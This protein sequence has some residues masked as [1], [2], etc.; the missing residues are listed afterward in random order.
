MSEFNQEEQG[1]QFSSSYQ[2]TQNQ[3]YM[4][5]KPDNNLVL[6]I[7]STVLGLCSPC[8]IG[9]ILGIIAIVFSTQVDSKYTMGDYQG[10]EKSAKTARILAFI[11]LG[12][13]ALNVLYFIFLIITGGLSAITDQYQQILDQVQ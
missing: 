3:D 1:T 7:V 5:T 6:S 10:A 8:C 9:L 4:P 2:S 11:A 12:F 13:F